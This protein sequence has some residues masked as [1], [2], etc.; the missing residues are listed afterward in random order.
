MHLIGPKPRGNTC[1]NLIHLI[2]ENDNLS[3]DKGPNNPFLGMICEVLGRLNTPALQEFSLGYEDIWSASGFD[4]FI[5][6]SKCELEK[7]EFLGIK[8]S[9]KDL[10]CAVGKNP[11]L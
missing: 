9:D 11:Q 3:F 10:Y 7:L 6:N 4:R 1:A 5:D 2:L 8:M